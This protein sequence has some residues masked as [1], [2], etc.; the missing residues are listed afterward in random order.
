MGA[1]LFAACGDSDK[2]GIVTFSGDVQPIFTSI[3]AVTGCHVEGHE[4]GLDLREDHSYAL[5]VDVGSEHYPPMKRVVPGEPDS[6]V[7]YLKVSGDP[8]TGDRM[9]L[10]GPALSA[11]QI[12]HIRTWILEGAQ[13]D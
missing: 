5:L 4:T 7:L 11:R 1:I 2:D 8:I 3:C 13:D 12:D 9:P 6:S 10:G